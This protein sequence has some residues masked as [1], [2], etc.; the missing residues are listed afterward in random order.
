ML[1][2]SDVR[3]FLC[4]FSEQLGGVVSPAS[5]LNLSCNSCLFSVSEAN[6]YGIHEKLRRMEN[7]W[8]LSKPAAF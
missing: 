8:N 5:Q 3:F 2:A 6:W 1:S 4:G 7:A